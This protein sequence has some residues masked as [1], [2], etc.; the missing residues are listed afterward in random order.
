MKKKKRLVKKMLLRV[1]MRC[2]RRLEEDEAPN[3]TW[4][5]LMLWGLTLLDKTLALQNRR[6][7]HS[8]RGHYSQKENEARLASLR[9]QIGDLEHARGEAGRRGE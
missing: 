9:R 4:V 7:T 8:V 2:E 5:S 1:D 3:P 6:V